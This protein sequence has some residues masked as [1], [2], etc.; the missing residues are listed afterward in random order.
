MK[1]NYL[2][3]VEIKTYLKVNHE[4]FLVDQFPEPLLYKNRK[5]KKI[6]D[7]SYIEGAIE[8]KVGNRLL[9]TREMWDYIDSLWAY[10]INSLEELNHRKES[11]TYFPDQ[12]IQIS[13]STQKVGRNISAVK[14]G[15]T[16][17]PSAPIRTV[18]EYD[19]FVSRMIDAARLYFESMLE[20]APENSGSYRYFLT[21]LSTMEGVSRDLENR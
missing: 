12:P 20:I 7:S 2:D 13:M 10:I 9:L 6:W 18:V 5:N 17:P 11:T 14:I 3:E 1:A 15:V 8:L 4:F 16:V 19:P 21:Q